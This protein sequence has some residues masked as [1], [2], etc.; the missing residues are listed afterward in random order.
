VIESTWM[1]ATDNYKSFLKDEV[2][3]GFVLRRPDPCAIVI[4]GAFGDLARRKLFPALHDLACRDLLPADYVIIGADVRPTT[5]AQFRKEV[6][7][8]L[9]QYHHDGL[10]E[11]AWQKLKPHLH[12]VQVGNQP[13]L[14]NLEDE[15]DRLDAKQK[16]GG[17]RVY[18]LAVPPNVMDI[19]AAQL[20]TR[21]SASGWTR[22]IVEKPFG[23]DRESAS[24]LNQKLRLHFSED[25]I[26][27]IDHY[28]GKT[29]VENISVLRWAN[30][31]FEP[32]WNRDHVDN[33]QITVAEEIGIEGRA[34][35][36]EQSGALKD[37]FQN[38]LLQLLTLT[39]MEPPNDLKADSVRNE[40]LKVLRAM[41]TP[42]AK[43][44]VRGQ[45][46]PGAI[47]GQPVLGY[48]EEPGVERTSDTETYI[49]AK[50]YVDNGRWSEVPFYVR[51]GKRLPRRE[52]TI[53]LQFKPTPHP[54]FG[55]SRLHRNTLTINIQPDEGASLQINTKTPG[56]SSGV[57]PSEMDFD[58]STENMPGPY[59]RLIHDCLVGDAT[60]FT[61]ADEVDE[62]WALTDAI[63]S[64]F[65][66][67]DPGFPNYRAGSWGPDAADDLLRRDGRG[68]VRR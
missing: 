9:A 21:R 25:E 28:L 41:Y 12:Y 62:Q 31:L 64:T 19:L 46:A 45:Y 66:R 59:E 54:M 33:V 5:V 67:G 42:S 30:G 39:A 52:T 34:D 57:Q 40:K 63:A 23:H 14:D 43:H 65:E 48:R 27:R 49:A 55:G 51:T 47:A 38:H 24:E 3:S 50:L 13:G 17:N 10:D 56:Q 7:D 11:A 22:L 35:F 36:Y 32:L 29:T 4:F 61:R 53:V 37:V 26:F 16:L 58:Y 44:L 15:I 18:Y 1:T 60:L 2:H 6:H 8:S 68:W 20:G